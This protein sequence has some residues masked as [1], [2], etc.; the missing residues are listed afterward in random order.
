[1]FKILECANV[2]FYRDIPTLSGNLPWI[3]SEFVLLTIE[4]YDF[5]IECAL[6]IALLKCKFTAEIWDK[7]GQSREPTF[8]HSKIL[9]IRLSST[10]LK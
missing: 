7:V 5:V 6:S 10:T 1:M 2:G 4:T 9:N 8:A 3:W